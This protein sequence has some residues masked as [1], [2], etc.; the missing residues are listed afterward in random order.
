ME[1][2]VL[3]W[4]NVKTPSAMRRMRKAEPPLAGLAVARG[5]C[6]TRAKHARHPAC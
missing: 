2:M 1:G 4:Q 3:R 6:R 5:G